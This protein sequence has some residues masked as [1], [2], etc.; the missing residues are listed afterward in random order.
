M[1]HKPSGPG[2][3][4]NPEPS[5]LALVLSVRQGGTMSSCEFCALAVDHC[6]SLFYLLQNGGEGLARWLGGKG[7]WC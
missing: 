7:I 1:V 5:S 2:V 6:L 3:G 4:S